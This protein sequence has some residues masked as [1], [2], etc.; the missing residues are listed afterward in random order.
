V[1]PGP[2]RPGRS[3]AQRDL[4]LHA[5]YRSRCSRLRHRHRRANDPPGLRWASGRGIHGHQ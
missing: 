4:H 3:A 2:H 5:V 1:G